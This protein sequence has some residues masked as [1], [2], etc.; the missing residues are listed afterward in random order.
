MPVCRVRYFYNK[1]KDK[2]S[3]VEKANCTSELERVPYYLFFRD[4]ELH[5]HNYVEKELA[6]YKV[7]NNC[8]QYVE[9]NL[10]KHFFNYKTRRIEIRNRY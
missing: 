10:K 4:A 6:K 3:I 5:K 9:K 2:L 7:C 8:Y 1:N